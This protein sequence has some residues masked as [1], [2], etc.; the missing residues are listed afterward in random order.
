MAM[1]G[2]VHR[3][4]AVKSNTSA[5]FH[6]EKDGELKKRPAHYGPQRADKDKKK[7]ILIGTCGKEEK[8]VECDFG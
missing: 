4:Q 2:G 7:K 3:E 5:L 8:N 1:G 6:P